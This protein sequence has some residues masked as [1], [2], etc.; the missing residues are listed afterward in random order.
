[1]LERLRAGLGVP[2]LLLAV[3]GGMLGEGSVVRLHA[4]SDLLIGLA[5]CSILVALALLAR[6]RRDLAFRGLF[7]MFAASILALGVTHFV[8]LA[9]LSVPV[10]LEGVVKLVTALLAVLTAAALWRSLPRILALP[11]PEQVLR[12]TEVAWQET[13]DSAA[14]GI[15]HTSPDDGRWRRFNDALCRITGYS[16]A[17]LEATTFQAITHP[18]DLA[19]GMALTAQLVAGEIPAFS[20]E[21]RYFRKDGTIVWVNLTVSLHRIRLP[22]EESY[23]IA[24]VQDITARKKAEEGRREAEALFRTLTE[25]MPSMAWVRRHDGPYEYLNPQWHAYTGWTAEDLAGRGHFELIHPE[26]LPMMAELHQASMLSGEGHFVEFRHRRHDGAWRWTESRVA[27]VRDTQ[28]NVL[29]WVGTLTDV[30]DQRQERERLLENERA[31]R[32]EAE[33]AS[34]LKDEFLAIVSH[35]LRTPLTVILGWSQLLLVSKIAEAEL[36]RGLETIRRSARSQA[37]IIDDLLD[38]SR[39]I[40]GK[41]RLD[42][43]TVDLPQILEKALDS[44]RPAAMAKGVRLEAM[45]LPSLLAKGDP[46][47]LQQIL[48]NLLSNAIRFTPQGGKVQVAAERVGSHLEVTVS[49]TGE[50]IDPEFLPYIFDRFRQQDGSTTRTHGGLGLGLSIVKNLVELHSGEVRASSAGLGKGST[51]IFQLP[52]SLT[53]LA[54]PPESPRGVDATLFEEPGDPSLAGLKILVVDDEPDTR[55][56][57]QRLLESGGALV[58]LAA[59]AREALVLLRQEKPCLLISDIGMPQ[60]DGYWLIQQV[61]ALAPEDGGAIPAVA[62][63]ALA[64]AEDRLRAL[65]AGFQ[66]HTAKPVETAELIYV[67]AGL[68]GRTAR[69]RRA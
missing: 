17:E 60:E 34:R 6:K 41:I 55:E 43:Q 52:L 31:A 63:T 46:G 30:H 49:D 57:L 16:R 25:G 21:K 54:E 53:D 3:T 67:A 20:L 19:P 23:F 50:G 68:A 66:A 12:A 1:M 14:V 7:W 62:L 28:G 4:V 32:N 26:D 22:H 48:W 69:A 2:P 35:E 59:S 56:V 45:I 9:A 15:A 18:D 65:R 51:F 11:S 42:L 8:S 44:V 27:P 33:E 58:L 5:C 38:M 64:R 10:W 13:F 61:R 24:M 39:I 40:A 47:R 29:R 37:Q 36:Q